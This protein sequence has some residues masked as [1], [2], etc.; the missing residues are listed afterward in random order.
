MKKVTDTHNQSFFG[1]ST[2][3]ILQSSS[4]KEPFI[5]MRFIKKKENGVWEKSSIGE[6]KTIKCNMEEMVMILEVLKKNIKSW[7]TVHSFKDD[8]TSISINWEGESKMW[9]N[10]GDYPK[11]MNFAQVEI[12]KML[13]EHILKEKI[14][15]ATTSDGSKKP[16]ILDATIDK[17]ETKDQINLEI[18]EEVEVRANI[19]SLQGVIAGET[20]KT[21]LVTIDGGT[22][23]WIPKSIIKSKYNFANKSE[24]NFLVDSWFIEKNNLVKT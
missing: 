21:L 13:L 9:F 15:N 3:M 12:L 7:S 18:I 17:T 16:N 6:G 10:V 24:Q 20:E 14:E 22:N 2:G 19:K 5:F 11:I 1:Q 4:K 23:V 8:K